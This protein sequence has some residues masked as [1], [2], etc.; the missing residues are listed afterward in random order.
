MLIVCLQLVSSCASNART[1][2]HFTTGVPNIKCIG[3]IRRWFGVA[4][5]ANA[6]SIAQSELHVPV[7][8]QGSSG[9]VMVR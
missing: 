5:R 3:G 4:D 7:P 2:S 8:V 9:S 6:I 1:A